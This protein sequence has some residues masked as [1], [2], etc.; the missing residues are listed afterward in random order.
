MELMSIID[1]LLVS[2]SQYSTCK[3]T[4]LASEGVYIVT[5]THPL[6]ESCE[7]MEIKKDPRCPSN[8]TIHEDVIVLN[9]K[10]EHFEIPKA[11]D[12]PT[13]VRDS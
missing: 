9:V 10:E 13:V 12:G 8:C 5:L 3:E 4:F 2:H 1:A 7:I 11:T 6:T